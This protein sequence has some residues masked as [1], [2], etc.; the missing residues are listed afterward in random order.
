MDSERRHELQKNDLEVLLRVKLPEFWRKHGNRLMWML[1]LA[2][3]VILV[4]VY[5]RNQVRAET[6]ALAQNTSVA[7]DFSQQ[8]RRLLQSPRVVWTD[9]TVKGVVTQVADIE[10][11]ANS[12]IGS[13][14]TPTQKA[15]A[16]LA[17]ADTFWAMSN[18]S[19]ELFEKAT[20]LGAVR[21]A[22]QFRTEAEASFN[23][24]V[25]LHENEREPVMSA[26][27]GLATIAEDRRDFE[28]A[29]LRYEQIIN[30]KLSTEVYKAS[31]RQRL[32]N[33]PEIAKS[34]FIMI[35]PA[36]QPTTVPTGAATTVPTT[37]P[38]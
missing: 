27:F 16:I 8:L 5:R 33:L 20:T 21:S 28:Q 7:I 26:L 30:D 38:G 17:R 12:V 10:T 32:D 34:L 4:L 2:M 9:E 31:A 14:A 19:S 6:S 3:L 11:A 36:T 1:T 24:I 13:D 25:R 23:D 15:Y 37:M 29:K 35:P 22:E 18:A